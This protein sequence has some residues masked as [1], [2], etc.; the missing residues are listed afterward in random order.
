MTRIWTTGAA[1]TWTYQP[2][3]TVTVPARAGLR[4]A[5][6]LFWDSLV[7]LWH[8]DTVTFYASDDATLFQTYTVE[9]GENT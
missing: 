7:A 4:I 5:L 3:M 8:H 9:T 6:R 2:Q 1:K